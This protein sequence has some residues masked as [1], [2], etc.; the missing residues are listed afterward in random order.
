MVEAMH[1]ASRP[2]VPGVSL[3]T[4]LC[5]AALGGA[6]RPAGAQ[7]FEAVGIRAQGLGGAFVAVADDATAT[8]WNPAGIAG[9]PYFD[10]ELEIDH[11]QQP[12]RERD[13]AGQTVPA[14][15]TGARAVAITLPALGLSYYRLRVSQIQPGTST[16][17]GPDGR[18]D[19]RTANVRL[20]A[21]VLQQFGVTVGQSVGEH[22][23]VATTV[24]VLR[25]RSAAQ[26]SP[27]DAASLDRADDLEGPAETHGGLDVGAMAT[28]G[29]IRLGLTVRNAT[30][31]TF[32]KD[33]NQVTLD[34][35]ARAGISV[36]GPDRGVLDRL[37][38]AFDAD[39]TRT[40]T[41]VGDE[42]RVA[43]GIEAWLF[44]RRV[45]VRGGVSGDTIGDTQ[46]AISGGLSLA[47]RSGLY[48]EGMVTGGSDVTRRGWGSDLRLTF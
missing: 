38:V 24:K 42:R 11:A 44:G 29:A 10:A 34:R 26:E 20:S 22:L 23:V 39:L 2:L 13:A 4:S 19:Q 18:Q 41:A 16:A 40:T 5:L 15:R 47:L 27:D 37:T 28:F 3:V 45:G 46:G 14:W 9:G 43:G 33:A 8:W 32:G 25:G 30:Q 12:R 35:Q 36:S 1:R 7:T 48:V 21:L 17:P 6:V 31:P